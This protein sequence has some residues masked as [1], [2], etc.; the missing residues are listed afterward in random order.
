MSNTIDEIS[1]ILGNTVDIK[2]TNNI[3]LTG[4]IFS[5]LKPNNILIS[6]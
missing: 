2:L 1:K 3:T 6:K 5:F 4:M